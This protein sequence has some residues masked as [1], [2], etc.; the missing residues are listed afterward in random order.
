MNA[1]LRFRLGSGLVRSL[2]LAASL[3]AATVALPAQAQQADVGAP[4]DGWELTFSPY[5]Y[6]F[7]RDGEY[8]NVVL[9][10][11]ERH[12]TS[13]WLWGG[14]LFSNSFGQPSGT[15]YVGYEWNKAFGVSPLYF[16][17]VGGIMY[18]YVDEYEDKVPFNH[19]GFSPIILPGVGW[20]FTPKDAAQIILLGGNGF[21]FSYN[22][23][24]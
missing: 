2:A 8:K 14:A 13:N 22:R 24:F 6:H 20:R 5:S 15:V 1:P 17:L 3:A 11:L 10:G 18:G 19:N 7:N 16:K 9:V 21:M 12:Y 23:R 4:F